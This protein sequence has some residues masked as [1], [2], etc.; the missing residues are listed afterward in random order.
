MELWIWNRSNISATMKIDDI[1]KV[2][3]GREKVKDR[4]AKSRG[5]MEGV[6]SS[7]LRSRGER[8][9]GW[10]TELEAKEEREGIHRME[11]ILQGYRFLKASR[12]IL[13][14]I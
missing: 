11:A 2:H 9:L 6:G 3:V 5:A 8:G 1:A 13:M 14:Y 4:N 7:S 12:M 10:Y